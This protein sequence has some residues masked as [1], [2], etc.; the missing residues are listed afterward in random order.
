M[1]VFIYRRQNSDSARALSEALR[2]RRVREVAAREGRR[3]IRAG[4]HVICW[5]E[6]LAPRDGV[7]ILNGAPLATKFEDATRLRQENVPTIEVVRMAPAVVDRTTGPRNR[8]NQV[9]G[10]LRGAVNTRALQPLTEVEP[11][12]LVETAYNGYRTALQAFRAVQNNPGVAQVWLARLNAHIG[13]NDLMRPPTRPDFFVKKEDLVQEF[14]VHSF[15]GRSI[16]AGIKRQSGPVPPNQP[17]A[18]WVRSYD[19]GW[20][21]HYG[22]G[23]RQMHRDIAHRACRVL[24]LDFGAVDVGQRADGSL[25]VLEVN[26]APGLADGTVEAYATAIHNWMENGR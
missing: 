23:I 26:R 16:R 5:G 17:T 11:D 3:Q 22:E 9:L 18:T 7:R 6:R 4:D 24:G 14:R 19:N 20:R 8:L 13:G 10:T 2:A 1:A 21:M 12:R 15:L 25:V